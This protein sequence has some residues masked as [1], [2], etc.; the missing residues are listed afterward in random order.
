M[1]HTK[2]AFLILETLYFSI[3][4]YEK[5][6]GRIC[7]LAMLDLAV[8][9]PSNCA[10]TA[11]NASMVRRWFRALASNH[12]WCEGSVIMINTQ[13]GEKSCMSHD[14][15]TQNVDV[16]TRCTRFTVRLIQWSNPRHA[17]ATASHLMM[18]RSHIARHMVPTSTDRHSH[19]VIHGY[20]PVESTL[21][22]HIPML[23]DEQFSVCHSR[24]RHQNKEQR[25]WAECHQ[26]DIHHS[27]RASSRGGKRFPIS[28]Q[29]SASGRAWLTGD[30]R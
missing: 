20:S 18:T 23:Q 4:I 11:I 9:L 29:W 12:V 19:T 10:T 26:Q 30:E 8:L 2:V 7:D 16:L 14:F 28:E 25:C 24:C 22:P 6:L 17:H 1:I 15:S 3:N 27:C 13:H 21:R 5:S